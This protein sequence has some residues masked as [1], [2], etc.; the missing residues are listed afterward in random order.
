MILT[1]IK[2]VCAASACIVFAYVFGST[3]RKRRLRY[4]YAMG[5]RGIRR[6]IKEID[7]ELG[8]SNV[9]EYRTEYSY[10]LYYHYGAMGYECEI[11]LFGI[12]IRYE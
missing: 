12:R 10:Y 5:W 7:K 2:V 11:L 8:R 4:E 1:T 9:V 3:P 6:Q